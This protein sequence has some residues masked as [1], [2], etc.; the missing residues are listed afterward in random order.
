METL[1]IADVDRLKSDLVARLERSAKLI[2][3]SYLADM[4]R[5]GHCGADIFGRSMTI[6]GAAA[7]QAA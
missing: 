5:Q 3:S 6:A 4:V 7:R 1:Q 2:S